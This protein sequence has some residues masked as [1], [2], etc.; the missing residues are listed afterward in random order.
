MQQALLSWSERTRRDLPWRHTRDPWA[1]LVS[2]LMLQQTQVPR[3]V[4]KYHSFLARF[5]TAAVCASS[6]V[7]DVVREW[8]GLGYNRR[9]VSLHRAAVAVVERHGGALPG[10]LEALLALPGIGPYTA[11]AVLTFAFGHD[12]GIVESNTGRVLARVAGQPLDPAE[13]QNLADEL[14][15]SGHG[16]AWNQAMIDLGATICLRR[17]PRCGVCPVSTHCG[18]QGGPDPAAPA[19]R[20]STFAGSDRQG[21][22][23]LVDAMRVAPVPVDRIPGAAGWPDDPA[24]AHRVADTLV[25]D[26]LAIE[27]D[28]ALRL[29]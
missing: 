16:W 3:V 24:R 14:V 17:A 23:R 18:W 11:H 10:D 5:P 13:A 9:A 19:H 15:P 8:A 26:G 2:E 4:P 29:P 21:R 20:Q 1:I 25:A 12:V 22:G 28:G 6:S 27:V 7:A